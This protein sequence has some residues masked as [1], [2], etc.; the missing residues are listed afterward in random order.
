MK[1]GK[2]IRPFSS[3]AKIHC[4]AY[5]TPL[6]RVI[7]DFGS[8][9]SF[10][11]TARLLKD[12]YGLEDVSISS[13]RLITE[14]HAHIIRQNITNLQKK[15]SISATEQIIMEAD[16][17]MVPIITM[18]EEATDKRKTRTVGWM[19]NKLSLAYAKGTIKPVYASTMEGVEVAGNQL[20]HLANLVG[21]NDKSHIHF[22]G[23]G[24]IW[25]VNQVE[26]QFGT[27]ANFLIDFFHLSE[28]LHKASLCCDS[29][30]A[31]AW[32][33]IQKQRM[34]EGNIV[35]VMQELE[36]HINQDKKTSDHQ[37][38]A[39]TC[40]NYMD[41]RLKQLN[42]KD[43]IASD[44]PIGS[45]KI[46]SGHRSVIQ[47]R[48]KLSGAWWLKENADAMGSLRVLKVNGYYDNYWN[49]GKMSEFRCN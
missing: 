27:Q 32:T 33:N 19:E 3:S 35:A 22:I 7:V 47:K 12:H 5:S 39:E 38:E 9:V 49:K 10:T 8:E 26:E 40:Y 13:I 45:G 4:K 21:R 46:E 36:R 31:L 34:K 16:G 48:L 30:H 17:G 28:Y 15:R 18:Q 41:R 1:A 14:R 24:A 37:C 2:S 20:T 6:Q 23:D 43:A 29:E 44:L 25:I 42:Y 11:E